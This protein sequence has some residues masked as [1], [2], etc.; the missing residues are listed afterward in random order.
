MNFGLKK[1]TKAVIPDQRTLLDYE[2]C[3]KK[4]RKRL[5]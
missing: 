1:V 3:C 4:Y 5:I 2:N